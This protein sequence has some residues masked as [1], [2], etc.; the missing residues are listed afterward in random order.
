MGSSH[1]DRNHLKPGIEMGHDSN[2]QN[3]L[4]LMEG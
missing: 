2:D 1:N 4:K 3:H